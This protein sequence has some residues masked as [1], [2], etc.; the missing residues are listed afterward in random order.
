MGLVNLGVMTYYWDMLF[1][2]K[3]VF[4]KIKTYHMIIISLTMS[5]AI[6]EASDD[7]I[8]KECNVCPPNKFPIG[9]IMPFDLDECPHGWKEFKMHTANIETIDSV[10]I[11]AV[12]SYA[13]DIEPPPGYLI[14]DGASYSQLEYPELFSVLGGIYGSK[15]APGPDIF[16]NVPDYRGYFLRGW[17]HNAGNDPDS[18]LRTD[19]GDKTI[20]D[21]VGTKQMSS[22]AMPRNPFTISLNGEHKHHVNKAGEHQHS[23]SEDGGHKHTFEG[24]LKGWS[25]GHGASNRAEYWGPK[26]TSWDG[27][28]THVVHK[29]GLHLHD[30]S[31]SGRHGH[32]IKG[33]DVETR[34]RNINV[35][36]FIK[37]NHSYPN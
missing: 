10:P 8:L 5:L 25:R 30:I 24:A 31:D 4:R 11:G 16:F 32:D 12:I 13:S 34:P 21:N 14:C 33:G 1:M 17:S 19:R 20:G 27:T 26:E 15:V 9:I 7:S 3:M 23:L 18:A 36:Y 28:H 2:I 35:Q 37:Q 22:T 6:T 29:S